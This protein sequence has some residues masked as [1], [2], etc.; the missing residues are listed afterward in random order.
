MHNEWLAMEH[1]RLHVIEQWADS[2]RKAAAL[3]AVRSA[4]ESLEPGWPPGAP[5]FACL[6]CHGSN[7]SGAAQPAR[8]FVVG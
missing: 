2:P 8:R 5:S 4:I 7:R 3:A 6:I 1:Y